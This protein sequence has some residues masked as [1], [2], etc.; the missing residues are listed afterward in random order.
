MEC[1]LKEIPKIFDL[2]IL[3]GVDRNSPNTQGRFNDFIYYSPSKNNF[4][5]QYTSMEVAH[6]LELGNLA[7]GNSKA[8]T[9]LDLITHSELTIFG[10][11]KSV[12]WLG[13]NCFVFLAYLY[14][15]DINFMKFV[16]IDLEKGFQ[17]IPHLKYQEHWVNDVRLEDL[18]EFIPYSPEIFVE[19]MTKA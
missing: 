13:D 1:G 16:A 12:F 2:S 17:I 15:N 18:K 11:N 19:R 9:S 3:P 14:K 7:W 6:G 5:I 4:V 10:F 8:K